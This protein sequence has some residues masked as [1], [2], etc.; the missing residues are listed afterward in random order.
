MF[1][2]KIYKDDDLLLGAN[3]AIMNN[4]FINGWVL[5]GTLEGLFSDNFKTKFW[6][7]TIVIG[8]LDGIPICVVYNAKI[9]DTSKIYQPYEEIQAFCKEEHRRKGYTSQ[10]VKVINPHTQADCSEG[11]K[12]SLMFWKKHGLTGR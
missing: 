6:D 11:I 7:I 8:E 10:C 5:Y 12:G 2:I 1:K 4:L 9:K 3:I